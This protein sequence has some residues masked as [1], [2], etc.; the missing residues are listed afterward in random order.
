LLN[1]DP[2]DR[3][4]AGIDQKSDLV[5]AAAVDLVVDQLHRNERGVPALQKLVLIEGV[6]V[7]GATA[8]GRPV[9]KKTY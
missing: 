1:R 2:K 8:V 5:G 7:E 9:S 6:W 4:F 3:G